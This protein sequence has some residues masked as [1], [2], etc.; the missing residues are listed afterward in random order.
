MK[1]KTKY[2]IVSSL[3]GWWRKSHT[4]L[5]S[6]FGFKWHDDELPFH[7]AS[8]FNSLLRD[9]HW[10]SSSIVF[11]GNRQLQQAGEEIDW[12]DRLLDLHL[13]WLLIVSHRRAL[14]YLRSAS[15]WCIAGDDT[16]HFTVRWGVKSSIYCVARGRYSVMTSSSLISHDESINHVEAQNSLESPRA[17]P[18]QQ[19]VKINREKKIK[20]DHFTLK[21]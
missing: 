5:V 8:A 15:R 18:P 19:N 1:P 2:K 9:V 11:K 10:K 17:F 20:S 14:L 13:S 3:L 6:R 12:L 21:L 16:R 4:E 7:Y